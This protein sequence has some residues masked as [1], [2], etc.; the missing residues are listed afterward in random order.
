MNLTEKLKKE[1]T[2]KISGAMLMYIANVLRE[3]Q[4]AIMRSLA[5]VALDMDIDKVDQLGEMAMANEIVGQTVM[6]MI[7][8]IIGKDDFEKFLDGKLGIEAPAIMP[9]TGTIN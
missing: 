1:A 6:D 2:V 3:R 8:V 9:S 4:I 7:E 5:D